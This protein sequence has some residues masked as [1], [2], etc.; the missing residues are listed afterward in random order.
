MKPVSEWT[1]DE[2][3][4]QHA[5]IIDHQK[6]IIL[7]AEITDDWLVWF[8][9][10]AL[11]YDIYYELMKRGRYPNGDIRPPMAR[12]GVNFTDEQKTVI[13]RWVDAG[14]DEAARQIILD[15][16]DKQTASDTPPP[17]G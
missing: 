5:L 11:A 15:E 8:Y 12:L 16:L 13:R 1:I 6:P 3:V 4:Q 17:E 7:Q 9:N 14:D 2:L 10:E